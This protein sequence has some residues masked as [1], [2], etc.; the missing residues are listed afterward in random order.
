MQ[1][2][3]TVLTALDS[4]YDS[5]K[6]EHEDHLTKNIPASILAMPK[7]HLKAMTNKYLEERGLNLT[8]LGES[9]SDS[10]DDS[11]TECEGPLTCHHRLKKI[12]YIP[13]VN[14][15]EKVRQYKES[16]KISHE[17]SKSVTALPTVE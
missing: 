2:K 1:G 16:K 9:N 11:S 7:S 10:D 6:V 14:W 8:G 15:R 13:K 17:Q 12:E 5:P 4:M 3:A